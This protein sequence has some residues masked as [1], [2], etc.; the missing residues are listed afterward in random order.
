MSDPVVQTKIIY[1]DRFVKYHTDFYDKRVV[2]KPFLPNYLDAVIGQYDEDT[3]IHVVVYDCKD[4]DGKTYISESMDS[5]NKENVVVHII[6][7]RSYYSIPNCPKVYYYV[8]IGK[9]TDKKVQKLK[10]LI[11]NDPKKDD[12]LLVVCEDYRAITLNYSRP[13]QDNP[14]TQ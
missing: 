3:I 1:D 6:N 4:E 8:E 10:E 5:L 7:P 11:D 13:T 9:E 14:I 2:H 12:I